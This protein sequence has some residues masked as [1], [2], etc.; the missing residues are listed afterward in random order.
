MYLYKRTSKL[1]E[2]KPTTQTLGATGEDGTEI[3]SGEITSQA[4][5]LDD[6]VHS[7]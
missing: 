1:T 7:L 2:L 5:E 6:L 3:K 4:T